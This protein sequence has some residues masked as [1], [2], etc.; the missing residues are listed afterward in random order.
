MRA[1]R[2]TTTLLAAI[3]AIVTCA[4]GLVTSGAAGGPSGLAPASS[5]LDASGL[6][7]T[8]IGGNTYGDQVREAKPRADGYRHIDTPKLIAKLER[9]NANLYLFQIWNSPTDWEDLTEEFAPAAQAAG[10]QVWPYIVPPSECQYFGADGSPLPPL[11]RGRC[12][13]PYGLDY[14]RWA[15]EVAKL[16]VKYPVVSGWAIDDFHIGQNSQT[17]TPEYMQQIKDAQDAVR[18]GLEFYT[19]A[20][21][22]AATDDAF[23]AKYAPYITGI[24]YPYLGLRSNLVDASEV[25]QTVDMIDPHTD[26]FGLDVMFLMY[27]NRFVGP[28]PHPN[29]RYIDTILGAVRPSIAAGQLKGVVA[30]GMPMDGT[31]ALN[32]DADA[33]TGVG[34]LSLSVSSSAPA[35][36]T[37]SASQTIV[38]DPDADR[39]AVTF[40]H[41]DWWARSPNGFGGFHSKQLL[42]DGQVVWDSDIMDGNIDE[43]SKTTVDITHALSDKTEA[44]LTFRLAV[45]RN[46]FFFP[47]DVRIDD[48]VGNGFSVDNRRFERLDGWDLTTTGQG[49]KPLI[50]V[51]SADMQQRIAHTVASHYARMAGEDPPA[52]VPTPSPPPRNRSSMYGP[53]R[54]SLVV[55]NHAAT[56][57]G[58]CASASQTVRPTP[59][60]RYELSFWQT[61]WWMAP[62]IGGHHRKQV[63]VDDTMVYNYDVNDTFGWSDWTQGAPLQGPIDITT[64]VAGKDAVTITF[65]LCETA[66]VT[67][68]P[69][70]VGFDNVTTVGLPLVNPGFDIDDGWTLRSDGNVH[71][72]LDN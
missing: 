40:W 15:E 54:L 26:A 71:A 36:S 16:S 47:V 14:V 49:V 23:L 63:L 5:P 70:D 32:S 60:P 2:T 19:T 65:R 27:A 30:Y 46:V 20:Y 21:L 56:D 48:V 72:A 43:W 55:G 6:R 7:G 50:D 51:W 1:F 52:F 4:A 11:Q 25:G 17:F 28:Q 42:V 44:T 45:R 35:G 64:L 29:D 38:V 67:D 58:Q 13:Q 66:G 9:T 12:S 68:L 22:S 34:R 69:V 62:A 10:I 37:A 33:R 3:A 53:G 57:A 59:S 31:P 41:S 61:D 39:Q 18:P 8:M 24:I